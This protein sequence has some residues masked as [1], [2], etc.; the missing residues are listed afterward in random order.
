MVNNNE[1]DNEGKLN[2]T[3][4]KKKASIRS[5]LKVIMVLICAGTFLY[6]AYSLYIIGSE[7]KKGTDEYRD[8]QKYVE[9]V[10]ANSKST[11]AWKIDFDN[12]KAINSDIVAWI[13]FESIG[14][15]YPIVKGTD[16]NFYLKHTFKKEENK[17]GSIFMDYENNS[18]FKDL[19][20]TIYG[21]NLKNSSMFSAL[22][23]YKDKDFYV[24]NPYF[25]IYT[26]N[27]DLKCEI[28]S[29]YIT[30]STSESYNKSFTTRDEYDKFLKT[31]KKNS[32]YDTGVEV[33]VDDKVLSLSTCTNSDK[34]SRIIVH[35]KVLKQ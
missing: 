18:Q 32:I 30:G 4:F 13:H 5:A 2:K 34:D 15:D 3:D 16:N 19:H 24:S 22:M 23:K 33:T 20:T 14:I 10:P 35:A 21:H 29:C 9:E 17:A 8:L 28:F 27:G 7:Y 25:W 6:S 26:P 11:K 1:K 31:L 12:L